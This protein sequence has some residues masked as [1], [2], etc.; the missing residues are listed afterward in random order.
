M[1]PEEKATINDRFS[2]YRLPT[3]DLEAGFQAYCVPV[4]PYFYNQSLEWAKPAYTT[5][6][7]TGPQLIGGD[8]NIQN[9]GTS[10]SGTV[11]ASSG[12]EIGGSSGSSESI[13]R[14]ASKS[15]DTKGRG[16]IRTDLLKF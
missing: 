3:I 12:T 11:E 8:I 15:I 13:I 1:T 5:Y 6:E 14:G 9:S 2:G 16:A 10:G 4:H 7:T